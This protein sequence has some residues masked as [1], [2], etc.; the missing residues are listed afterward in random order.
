MGNRKIV[1]MMLMDFLRATA[2]KVKLSARKPLTLHV[3]EVSFLSEYQS[4]LEE[5]INFELELMNE[6]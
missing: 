6:A 1:Y 4:Q 5:D 3:A 2:F